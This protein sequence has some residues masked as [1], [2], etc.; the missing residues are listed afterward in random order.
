MTGDAAPARLNVDSPQHAA[1]DEFAFQIEIHF[2]SESDSKIRRI[3]AKFRYPLSHRQRDCGDRNFGLSVR[4]DVVALDKT[5]AHD[6]ISRQELRMSMHNCENA[7]I[8]I[9]ISYKILN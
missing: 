8:F 4:G 6:F 7:P 5:A 3:S 9:T 1:G 2:W